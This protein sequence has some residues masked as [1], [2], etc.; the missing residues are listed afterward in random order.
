[1]LL[2][3][4]YYALS[5]TG[6]VLTNGCL[7]LYLY[8]NLT[9]LSYSLEPSSKQYLLVPP[10]STPLYYHEFKLAKPKTN[11]TTGF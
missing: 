1:M 3:K 10:K 5:R 7:R 2:E 11:G 8:T 9:S 6:T 4:F